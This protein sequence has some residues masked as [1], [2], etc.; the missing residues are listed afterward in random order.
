M[1][2]MF[3]ILPDQRR[4]ILIYL[5]YQTKLT[6]RRRALHLHEIHLI[7]VKK[8]I[9]IFHSVQLLNL[10]AKFHQHIFIKTHLVT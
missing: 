7:R 2:R 5:I 1:I 3:Q 9:L 6:T 8:T 10:L 4:K